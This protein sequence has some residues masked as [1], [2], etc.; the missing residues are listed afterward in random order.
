MAVKS[1]L[2]DI[3]EG[4]YY[5]LCFITLGAAYFLKIVIMKAI[6]DSQQK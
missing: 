3:S 5:V 6:I 4:W 2:P 1:S